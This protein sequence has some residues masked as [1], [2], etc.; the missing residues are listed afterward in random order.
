MK[1]ST[2]RDEE[3]VAI[4]KSGEAAR[5]VA[6]VCRANTITEQSST[7][8]ALLLCRKATRPRA[9]SAGLTHRQLAGTLRRI[10]ADL[11]HPWTVEG[12][13][14]DAAMSRSTFAALF[15]SVVGVPPLTYATTWHI[16][17]AKLLLARRPFERFGCAEN[18]RAALTG[19]SRG[20]FCRLATS[21][22]VF[23]VVPVTVSF[24]SSPLTTPW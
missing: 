2:F 8:A 6:D 24:I 22:I 1:R 20:Y 9:G 11:S 18:F 15:R 7:G 13:A 3:V 19:T 4:V 21:A 17:R 10:R 14:R 12:T 23:P 16:Y 5:R